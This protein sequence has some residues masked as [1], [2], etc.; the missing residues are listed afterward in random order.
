ME[1]QDNS[2]IKNQILNLLAADKGES[3]GDYPYPMLQKKALE[4]I[5]YNVTEAVYTSLEENSKL[6]STR[7]CNLLKFVN[8]I[9]QT[10]TF[11]LTQGGTKIYLNQHKKE[12]CDEAVPTIQ[13]LIQLIHNEIDELPLDIHS[14]VSSF[15]K[16]RNKCRKNKA[17]TLNYIKQIDKERLHND[18][19][20][21]QRNI[22]HYE[23]CQSLIDHLIVCGSEHS[24]IGSRIDSKEFRKKQVGFCYAVINVNNGECDKAIIDHMLEKLLTYKEL[25]LYELEFLEDLW[26]YED[27]Y[28]S[29]IVTKFPWIVEKIIIS[30]C[31]EIIKLTDGSQ[32][33]E[34]Y[35][36]LDKNKALLKVR[37]ECTANLELFLKLKNL[38]FELFV[39]SYC[40]ENVYKFSDYI[41]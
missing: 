24:H 19:M 11:Y 6:S 15:Y 41:I 29:S 23:T 26:L 30:C 39:F 38:I 10:P 31:A 4:S 33:S 34:Y 18:Q 5:A 1:E 9:C 14:Q 35:A 25:E 12:F 27:Y 8:N 32:V 36:S 3:T 7:R 16:R 21:L 28:T 37:K 2:F 22:S 17:R 13:P 20:H 40:N